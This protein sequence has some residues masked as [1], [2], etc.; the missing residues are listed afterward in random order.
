[1]KPRGQNLTLTN[2]QK[3]QRLNLPCHIIPVIET[4]NSYDG[5]VPRPRGML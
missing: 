5:D 1:M 4:V 3:I 2:H